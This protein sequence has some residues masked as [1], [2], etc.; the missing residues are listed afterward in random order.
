[1]LNAQKLDSQDKRP[2]VKRANYLVTETRPGVFA[3]RQ[4]SLD[5]QP[6]Q[7]NSIS[8]VVQV[9]GIPPETP[10]VAITGKLARLPNLTEL[11]LVITWGG[12]YTGRLAGM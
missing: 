6:G 2:G 11:P 5:E 9:Q 4:V 12:T 7:A 3:I 8:W 1:M 10:G